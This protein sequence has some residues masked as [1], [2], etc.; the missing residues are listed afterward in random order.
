MMPQLHQFTDPPMTTNQ[1]AIATFWN[2]QL[3]I[4]LGEDTDGTTFLLRMW[5]K[6]FVTLIWVGGALI[7]LGGA[8]SLLGRVRRDWW[9]NRWPW[10]ARRAGAPAEAAA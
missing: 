10:A 2:G 9:G 7:A 8:L 4:T 6:P 1:A 3:Y 5:W